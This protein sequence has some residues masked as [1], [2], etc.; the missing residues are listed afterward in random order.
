M[1]NR[2]GPKNQFWGLYPTEMRV[3]PH[4]DEKIL[5]VARRAERA[6]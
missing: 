3:T 5:E 1:I 6:C 4:E 2:A